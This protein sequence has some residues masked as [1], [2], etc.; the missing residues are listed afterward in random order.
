MIIAYLIT[1]NIANSQSLKPSRFALGLAQRTWERGFGL[2]S[3]MRPA[4]A[5]NYNDDFQLK[6]LLFF[7]LSY[8]SDLDSFLVLGLQTVERSRVAAHY[9]SLRMYSDHIRF[10]GKVWFPFNCPDR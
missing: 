10:P 3:L 6:K 1:K 8:E 5:R 4:K 7:F 9:A 2:I